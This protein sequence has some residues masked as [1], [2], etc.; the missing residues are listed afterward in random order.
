MLVYLDYRPQARELQFAQH[1]LWKTRQPLLRTK[2]TGQRINVKCMKMYPTIGCRG[3]STVCP[4]L[5]KYTFRLG[6]RPTMNNSTNA[7]TV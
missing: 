5:H 4:Y 2:D 1:S 6:Q 3:Y 7:S